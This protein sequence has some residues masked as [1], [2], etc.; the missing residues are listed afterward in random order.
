M[1]VELVSMSLYDLD[2]LQSLYCI[3][4]VLVFHQ[5]CFVSDNNGDLRRRGMVS[6]HNRLINN[7][8]NNGIYV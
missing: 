7:E 3:I 4:W 2:G 6:N 5:N 1:Q 8:T